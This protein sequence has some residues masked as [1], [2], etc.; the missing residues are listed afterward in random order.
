MNMFR[1]T[2]YV[3]HLQTQFL[4]KNN[5]A[6]HMSLEIIVQ[7]SKNTL[8][9]KMFEGLSSKNSSGKLSFISV[10][11]KFR[12]QLKVLM[13]KLRSTVSESEKFNRKIHI[14]LHIIANY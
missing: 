12:T 14:E 1:L 11:S 5:D 6:L 7:E 8:V 10:G 3:L 2:C 13:D 4:E 9:K